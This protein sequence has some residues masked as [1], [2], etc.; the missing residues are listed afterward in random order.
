METWRQSS[1]CTVYLRFTTM[2]GLGLAMA[3]GTLLLFDTLAI[4]AQ[5]SPTIS[6]V[7]PT[8]A[9][10]NLDTAITITGTNFESV[11]AV[12]LGNMS[13]QE[14]TWV[15]ATQLTAVVP[16]GILSGTYNLTVVNPGGASATLPHAFTVEQAIGVWTTGGPYGGGVTSLA[17]HPQISTTVYAHAGNGLYKSIDG[18]EWWEYVLPTTGGEV[19]LKPGTPQT[20]LASDGGRGLYRSLDGGDTW[21]K[22]A[23]GVTAFAMGAS[24]PHRLY[25]DVVDFGQGNSTIPVSLD[26]GESWQLS[27]TGLPTDVMAIS[28]AVHPLTDTIAYA[29]MEDGRVYTTTDGGGSWY[30]LAT[31]PGEPAG[32]L[33]LD[34][35]NPERVYAINQWGGVIHRS[36][37]GGVTWE[38]LDP[39]GASDLVFHPDISG[40]LFILDYDGVYSSTDAGETKS[41]VADLPESESG[42]AIQLDPVS[43]QPLYVGGRARGVFRSDDG[44]ATWR[45]VA[46]GMSALNT[47]GLAA[48]PVN[49]QQVYLASEV[50]GFVS[51]NA[52]H[53]WRTTN[54]SRAG[55]VAAH[56]TRPCEAYLASESSVFTT[57]DCGVSWSSV[58]LPPPPDTRDQYIP[59]LAVDPHYPNTIFAGKYIIAASSG[60]EYGQIYS[61]TDNG[62]S[63][64]EVNVG[65][66]ISGVWSIAFDPLVTGT[67]YFATGG[68]Y[69]SQIGAVY[70]STDGGAHWATKSDGLN[71]RPISKIV[72]DPSNSDV[73]YVGT[74]QSGDMPTSGGV[75][76]SLD[77]GD[78]WQDA[79]S[80][81][82][83][84]FGF[85]R[86]LVID[87]LA[88]QTLYA[89][90]AWHGLYRT[91][92]GGKTWTWAS[93]PLRNVT[94]GSL[95]DAA[96]ADGRT[97]IYVGTI[98][99]ASSGGAAAMSGI[100]AQDTVGIKGG[101]Y[102]QTIVHRWVYL[103]VV[104]KR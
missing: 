50:G 68:D 97:F 63:W 29:G 73:L 10:N 103:P 102:V 25:A 62:V 18:G 53:S 85:I 41:K 67:L 46:Q 99:G 57:A 69:S 87:P 31:S 88:P 12:M 70:K 55:A 56:P 81:V 48:S 82:E 86:S 4:H 43:H 58:S 36:L 35:L 9:S 27:G 74:Y 100:A 44:G 61:S 83:W 19:I 22:V 52:G 79:A 23:E 28:L 14:V 84:G 51:S 30:Q 76:K 104:M 32:K 20:V 42:W 7:S 91:T 2:L 47:S 49:P 45:V 95:A 92:D 89:G 60:D 59:T 5:T 96:T 11:P 78:T 77:G 66:P 3:L 65:H 24:S 72:I 17:V 8:S 80:G 101:V 94:I 26:D 75:L 90:D 16:W 64:Q 34:P 15:N 93:G 54:V 33:W 21:Q 71:G 98:G 13:L 40:T 6:E 1:H 39:P 38:D 37:D